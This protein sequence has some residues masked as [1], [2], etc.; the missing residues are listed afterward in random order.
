[1]TYRTRT[2]YPANPYPDWPEQYQRHRGIHFPP[3]LYVADPRD[4]RDGRWR[5][6]QRRHGIGIG[7]GLGAGVGIDCVHRGCGSSSD[8]PDGAPCCCRR[9]RCDEDRRQQHH[10][11]QQQ[12]QQQQQSQSLNLVVRPQQVFGGGVLQPIPAAPPSS[13][14]CLCRRRPSRPG[15]GCS[16]PGL[17]VAAAPWGSCVCV[18]ACRRR[19]GQRSLA[20]P[21]GDGLQL[22]GN[23][24]HCN[25]RRLGGG[26]SIAVQAPPRQAVLPYGAR[27]GGGGGG[28]GGA[29]VVLAP[30]NELPPMVQMRRSGPVRY[31]EVPDEDGS[32]FAVS[33][34][35]GQVFDDHHAMVENFLDL[36]LNSD[37]EDWF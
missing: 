26:A 33:N 1:M 4:F 30:L 10:H 24:V 32:L 6:F 14:G 11:Q 31:V 17:A 36:D 34:F 29:A 35:D 22:Q 19:R 18:C 3:D 5:D 23:H 12:Q 2:P 37:E 7:L 27:S 13:G 8:R 15:G 16:I 20:V 21:L 25:G 28:G 9:Y